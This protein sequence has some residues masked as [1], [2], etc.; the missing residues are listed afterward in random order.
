MVITACR[1]R[2]V[3]R[4]SFALA[5]LGVVLFDG[6][7]WGVNV[8]CFAL[9]LVG[10]FLHL[11]RRAGGAHDR[12][13]TLLAGAMLFWAAVFAWRDAAALQALAALAAMLTGYLA[14][15]RSGFAVLGAVP[16]GGAFAG[17]AAMVR[18]FA[19]RAPG[20][21]RWELDTRVI[22]GGRQCLRLA[23]LARGLA[24]ATPAVLVFGALLLSADARYRAA[25]HELLALDFIPL[26][27]HA[28]IF[29]ACLW[30]AVFALLVGALREG[31]C[32]RAWST[33]GL[34]QAPG[35]AIT[36]LALCNGVFASFLAVQFG[37]FFGGDALVR[38]HEPLTYAEYARGGFFQLVAV[39]ALAVPLLL[40]SDWL[41]LRA[42]TRAR[43]LHRG[44]AGAFIVQ[45]LVIEASALHR[46][47]LYAREFGL[48]E[49]RFYTTA[50]MVWV[51]LLLL[52]AA[53]V[54]FRDRREGF[55]AAASATALATAVLLV[56]VN[57]DARIAQ[58]NIARA[59]TGHAVDVQYLLT[60]SDDAVP[61]LIAER[62]S[63]RPAERRDLEHGLFLRRLD[64]GRPRPWQA[65]NASRHRAQR[66][67]AAMSGR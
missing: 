65:W 6:V 5:V 47:F 14:Y 66:A 27:R 35:E 45:V 28:G 26:L 10:V 17:G 23:P 49:L 63:L 9:V 22:P 58:V 7:T 42:G 62:A 1:P 48:T 19:W 52:S 12:L 44:F 56:L 57:P 21:V 41:T 64:R 31:V 8:A 51:T 15:L 39:A 16:I 55:V 30:L 40:T 25:A 32:P 37:Y 36:V 46:M 4:V 43:R 18:A 67:L 50:F 53:R 29:L 54:V 59:A 61:A 11:R 60:L 38:S 24:L 33:P 13:G 3:L 34:P 2:T 20:F